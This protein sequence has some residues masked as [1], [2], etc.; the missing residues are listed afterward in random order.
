MVKKYL[1][2]LLAAVLAL[3]ACSGVASPAATPTPSEPWTTHTEEPLGIRVSYPE[4][5][6]MKSEDGGLYL[7]DDEANF[8]SPVVPDGAAVV[9][10]TFP[11]SDFKD[12]T[13]PVK[14]LNVYHENFQALG[15]VLEPDGEPETLT[16]HDNPAAFARYTGTMFEQEGA[17]TL[18]AIVHDDTAAA[19]FT[20]DTTTGGIHKERL[21]RIAESVEFLK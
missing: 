19:V 9:I 18:T 14:L 15:G 3:A 2:V 1:L 17:F 6:A 20:M 8:G 11:T 21:R 16:I 12:I 5:W 4:A 7:S 13:D 10:A